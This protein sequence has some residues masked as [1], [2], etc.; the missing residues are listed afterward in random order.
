MRRFDT[1][2]ELDCSHQVLVGENAG[3]EKNATVSHGVFV[4]VC[5][6]LAS[7]IYKQPRVADSCQAAPM[8]CV[9]VCGEAGTSP[10]KV[11]RPGRSEWEVGSRGAP[12]RAPPRRRRPRL[13]T[14]RSDPT[15]TPAAAAP[16]PA[17]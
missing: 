2:H 9:C 1:S 6:L 12:S 17:A 16:G 11:A 15:W 8:A 13:L 4:R 10:V 7:A 3:S 14:L 5:F